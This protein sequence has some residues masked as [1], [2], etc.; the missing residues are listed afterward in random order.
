MKGDF[1]R[2]TFD[3]TRHFSQVFQQQGRVQLESDWN[4]QA[5]IGLY[6]LRTMVTDLV[7]PCW[8]AGTGFSI[9]RQ[10]LLANWQLSPGHFYVDGILCQNEAACTVATQPYAPTPGNGFDLAEPPTGFVVWL[11]V[12]ERH[13]SAIEAPS[14]LDAALEGV[15]TATRAQVVWQLR[16][17]DSAALG[18]QLDVLAVALKLRMG[19]DLSDADKAMLQ[20]QINELAALRRSL[21]AGQDDPCTILR[22]VLNAR[23]TYAW[24]RLR[25]QAGPVDSDDDPCVIAADARYRGL[26]NQLYRVEIHDGASIGP[27]GAAV[28]ATFKWSRENGSVIFPVTA[29][30]GGSAQDGSPQ[31]VVGLG[32]LGRDQR[33]GL[34]ANEWVEVLDDNVTLSQ[35]AAPLLQIVAI[36]ASSRTVTLQG[37]KGDTIA[38]PSLDPGRHALLRRWDQQDG[39][40]ADGVLPVAEGGWIILEDGLQVWFEPG[41]AYETGDYWQVPARVA[42]NGSLDW[43]TTNGAPDAVKSRGMHHRAALGVSTLRANYTECCCRVVSLCEQMRAASGAKKTTP[44]TVTPAPSKPLVPLTPGKLVG[45]TK[46]AKAA[47]K[48]RKATKATKAVKSTKA[49][50]PTRRGR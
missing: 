6:L 47:V 30:A 5:T 1:A 48:V 12:W 37:R 20:Q 35:L 43:S 44:G 22:A 18:P 15:D 2:V 17:T 50:K 24:P 7:G 38:L 49:V 39:V 27:N 4:E 3:P 14:I 25:A 32:N 31:L 26:E 11:D 41:G 21:D 29:A 42:G 36:D 16:L 9:T 46:T 23:A 34:A 28:G 19:G 33:L 45:P 8:A 10:N 40:S 13:L